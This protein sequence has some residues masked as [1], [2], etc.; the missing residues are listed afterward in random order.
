[1][2]PRRPYSGHKFRPVALTIAGFDPSAGAGVLAD[3]KTFENSGVYGIA[4]ITCNTH[5][6]DNVFEGITW[7]SKNEKEKILLC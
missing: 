2:L 6:N 5:Q 3:I 7:L 4:I 1:M